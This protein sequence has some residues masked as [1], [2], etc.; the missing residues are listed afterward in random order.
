VCARPSAQP[1]VV[2]PSC[3]LKAADVYPHP[4]GAKHNQTWSVRIMHMYKYMTPPC[5]MNN[6]SLL[7]PN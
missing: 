3:A 5:N 1:P 2:L 6:T 7:L 4:Y